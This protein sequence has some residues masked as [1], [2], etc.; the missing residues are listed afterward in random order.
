MDAITAELDDNGKWHW[1]P[2]QKLG[3]ELYYGFNWT[4]YITAENDIRSA[5]EYNVPTGLTQMATAINGDITLIKL[6]A[7]A[8]GVDY[9]VECSINS[10]EDDA[11]Q[12]QTKSA[13]LTIIA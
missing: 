11:E 9:E 1:K 2:D 7:D 4:E 5:V 3:T 8:V 6:R 10:A 13:F 12:I